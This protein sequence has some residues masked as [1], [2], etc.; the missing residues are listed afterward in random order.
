MLDHFDD[1][2]SLCSVV[3]AMNKPPL[4][5]QILTVMWITVR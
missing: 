4:A 3:F 2:S 1:K 5:P